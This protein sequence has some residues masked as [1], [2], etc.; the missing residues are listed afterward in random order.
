M[1]K[2]VGLG[3][4][5]GVWDNDEGSWDVTRVGCGRC[6]DKDEDKGGSVC[7]EE[8]DWGGGEGCIRD[9]SKVGS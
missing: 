6:E 4:G 3:A 7:E 1:A 8:A 2:D 5:V 9:E